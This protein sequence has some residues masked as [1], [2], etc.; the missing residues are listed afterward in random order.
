MSQPQQ[1]REARQGKQGR[2]A[3]SFL[4]IPDPLRNPKVPG[5]SGLSEDPG[6]TWIRKFNELKPS[7]PTFVLFKSH[8]PSRDFGGTVHTHPSTNLKIERGGIVRA[9]LYC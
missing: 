2:Q 8:M 5:A 4:K 1:A 9:S 6:R 7:M 3:A